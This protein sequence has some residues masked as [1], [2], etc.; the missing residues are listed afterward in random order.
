MAEK[1]PEG[2]EAAEQPPKKKS[3]LMLIVIIVVVV[4]ALGG[5]G[6]F[7]LLKGGDHAA[8]GEEGDE[9]AAEEPAHKKPKSKK[10]KGAHDAPPIF[11]KLEPFT[12][13]LMSEGQDSYLQATPE[14]RVLDAAL[15][16]TVKA[17]TPSIRHKVL[18]ILSGKK[19]AELSTPQGVQKLS[20]EVR[21][22]INHI[23]APPD[24]RRKPKG[25]PEEPGDIGEPDD[26]VQEVLFTSF[27]I[28]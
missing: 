11:V 15:G 5:G 7:F 22:A 20:N 10:E 18:L 24:P 21:V 14:L 23:L 8:D 1:K 16:D 27:I 28:Q 6:A 19:A 13:K 3:K 2:G 17:Y 12:V 4:A 26:P 9:P 25:A